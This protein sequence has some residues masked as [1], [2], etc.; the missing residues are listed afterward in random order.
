[1]GF[2]SPTPLAA[3]TSLRTLSLTNIPLASCE[4]LWAARQHLSS[5]RLQQLQPLTE[6]HLRPFSCSFKQLRH[7]HLE[8]LPLE[9]LPAVGGLQQLQQLTVKVWAPVHA[10]QHLPADAQ[11]AALAGLTQLR[12][13]SLA[14][15]I[16]VTQQSIQTL[17]AGLQGLTQLQLHVALP[18]GT[19]GLQEFS[20]VQQL[21]LKPYRARRA[22]HDGGN[23]DNLLEDASKSICVWPLALPPSLVTLEGE[24]LWFRSEHLDL[25]QQ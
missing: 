8:P 24:D 25:Q 16:L 3:A 18:D 23:S 13:L 11:L 2:T 6:E 21:R 22:A 5:L 1:V 12:S 14:G 15:P 7:L 17:A 10:G 9:L 4:G 20:R 19:Q